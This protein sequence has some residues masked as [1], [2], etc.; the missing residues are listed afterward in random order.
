MAGATFF[1]SSA[2]QGANQVI[3]LNG[4]SGLCRPLVGGVGSSTTTAGTGGVANARNC[5]AG[6]VLVGLSG[7]ADT[8]VRRVSLLCQS[9]TSAQAG[10]TS[11]TT[12][13]PAV[14]GRVVNPPAN[15]IQRRCP[16]GMAVRA[17]FG[18]AGYDLNQMRLVCE[19][20][21]SP[22]SLVPSDAALLGNVG[23][24][25]NETRSR[26]FCSDRGVMFGLYG[27]LDATNN[28]FARL[29]EQCEGTSRT[30]GSLIVRPGMIEHITPAEGDTDVDDTSDFDL[31]CASGFGLIGIVAGTNPSNGMISH[32]RGLCA[33][34]T[35]WDGPGISATMNTATIGQDFGNGVLSSC[36]A[37]HFVVAMGVRSQ[38]TTAGR[39]VET[40]VPI[41]RRIGG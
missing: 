18:R 26:E 16:P 34:I 4:F 9:L 7:R 40:I 2:G 30:A 3:N 21:N 32:V 36:P 20:V 17:V 31:T 39:R 28:N 15:N 29:G 19:A 22:A 35:Q 13:L 27:R 14:G 25:T 1:T 10:S 8:L 6:E 5:A 11:P 41:C 24:G 12:T 33:N 38:E 23:T 37:D